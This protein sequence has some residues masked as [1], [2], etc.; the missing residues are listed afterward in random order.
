M[1]KVLL[2]LLGIGLI[3]LAAIGIEKN[4]RNIQEPATGTVVVDPVEVEEVAVTPVEVEVVTE[5][6]VV[7]EEVAPVVEEFKPL[8]FTGKKL[9]KF[10]KTYK[11]VSHPIKHFITGRQLAYH[12]KTKTGVLVGTDLYFKSDHGLFVYRTATGK[13]IKL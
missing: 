4:V 11:G 9:R 7:I 12:G 5:E 10:R 13:F 1:R 3:V 8:P 6:E 2:V